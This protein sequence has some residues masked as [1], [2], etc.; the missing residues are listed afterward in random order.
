M[1]V[2]SAVLLGLSIGGVVTGGTLAGNGN[3]GAE[4]PAG[5]AS[6]L[7]Q[8]EMRPNQATSAG[9]EMTL[10]FG[11]S[12]LVAT[13]DAFKSALEQAVAPLQIDPRVT[14]LY[15]PY[16][17]PD[18]SNLM[19]RDKHHALVEVQLREKSSAAAKYYHELLAMVHP[20]PLTV[21]A[22]GQ[23]PLNDAFNTTLESDVQR[24]EVVALPIALLVAR[25]WPCP[26][27][28]SCSC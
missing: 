16:T 28:F 4:L 1:L 20:G 12:T 10:L 14:S 18:P 3:F 22:T 23:V 6:K 9:S 17:V 11:S 26:S 21:V 15:T 7:I 24:G 25:W 2:F 27:R 5:K 13:D 8:Q 19:S